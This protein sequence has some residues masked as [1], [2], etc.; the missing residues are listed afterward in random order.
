MV[1]L[2]GVCAHKILCMYV[3]ICLRMYVQC[4]RDENMPY[5]KHLR[6]HAIHICTHIHAY[7]CVPTYLQYDACKC[8][9]SGFL[10]CLDTRFPHILHYIT[11]VSENCSYEGYQHRQAR[12]GA[13]ELAR[14]HAHVHT[15]DTRTH[16]H[17]L[18]PIH[19]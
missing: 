4:P 13:H 2:R 8:N 17:A 5:I 1:S 16:A 9:F 11:R 10:P 19:P 12:T 18:V 6:V 14:L 7:V 15:H 3:P